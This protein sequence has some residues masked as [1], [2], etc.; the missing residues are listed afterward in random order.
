MLSLGSC[1][2]GRLY[3]IC[4]E[5]VQ[6]LIESL[7]LFMVPYLRREC[8]GSLSPQTILLGIV[9]LDIVLVFPAVCDR[10]KWAHCHMKT[11]RT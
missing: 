11:R 1:A 10:V 3:H 9:G 6:S 8:N 5:R 4:I 7:L 2:V